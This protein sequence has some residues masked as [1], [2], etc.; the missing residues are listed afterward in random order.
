[1]GGAPG[2]TAPG[3]PVP[4]GGALGQSMPTGEAPTMVGDAD[5]GGPAVL[6]SPNG[7]VKEESAPNGSGESGGVDEGLDAGSGESPGENIHV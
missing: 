3:G 4:V 2:V 1:M 6:A 5:G 7:A